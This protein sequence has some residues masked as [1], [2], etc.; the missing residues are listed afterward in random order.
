V[1]VLNAPALALLA[2]GNIGLAMFVEILADV[3]IRLSSSP[4]DIDWD[5]RTWIG[6]GALGSIERIES[7]AGETSGLRLA[8]S[9][10]TQDVL[11]IALSE[12]IRSKPVN[13]YLAIINPHHAFN[14][15]S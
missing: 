13:I 6:A 5:S 2:S 8:L 1:R 11:A 3:P 12:D 4:V 9:G 10:I 7:R 15:N 14:P